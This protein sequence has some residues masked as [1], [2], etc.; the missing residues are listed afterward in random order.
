MSNRIR[1][2]ILDDDPSILEI[3]SSAAQEAEFEF[4]IRESA[5]GFKSQDLSGYDLVVL[6]LLMPGV[7]GIEFLR[8][9]E[10]ATP[11]PSVV[12][13]SGMSGRH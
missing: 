10:A 2:L 8:T 12:L 13:M 1:C 9:L 3:A 4:E 11:S 6:D 7:D 5:L